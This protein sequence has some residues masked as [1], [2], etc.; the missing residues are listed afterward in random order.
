MIEVL[1]ASPAWLAIDKPAEIPTQAAGE[2]ESVE[3][4]MRNQLGTGSGYLAL[5]HRLDVGVSGVMLV[6][7]R[8]KSARLLSEQF[9][10]RKVAKTYHAVVSGDATGIERTWSDLIEKVPGQA[11]VQPVI[12]DHASGTPESAKLA[13]TEV[14]KV[15][16]DPRTSTSRLVLRPLTGRMHQLRIGAA[17]RGF[18]IMG[19]RL[20][21]GSTDAGKDHSQN[22]QHGIQLRS[23]RIEFHDPKN[24]KRLDV[25][26]KSLPWPICDGS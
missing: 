22:V 26:A 25:S 12:V 16:Y 6:A 20:Y 8:K 24:G 14:V 7:L 3:L 11:R 17:K 2:I 10:T 5:P 4:L 13:E 18:P 21:R 19:D 23:V 9:A 1:Q 15:D